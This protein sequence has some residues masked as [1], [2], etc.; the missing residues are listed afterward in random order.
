[1][2]WW[3]EG[4][5]SGGSKTRYYRATNREGKRIHLGTAEAILR[6]LRPA[7]FPGGRGE[8]EPPDT[9]RNGSSEEDEFIPEEEEPGP[10]AGPKEE[11]EVV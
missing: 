10:G 4:Y 9:P 7:L 5:K 11:N 6:K 2:T 1:M 3:I 8:A